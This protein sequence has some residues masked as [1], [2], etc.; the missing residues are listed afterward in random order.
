LAV[1]DI[2]IVGAY[3]PLLNLAAARGWITL[4]GPNG[5]R[6][7][8]GISAITRC[9]PDVLG[10]NLPWREQNQ[11]ISRAIIADLAVNEWCFGGGSSVA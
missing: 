11:D 8:V 9:Y 6:V 2:D 7:L 5:F 4:F 1:D 3:F 10:T